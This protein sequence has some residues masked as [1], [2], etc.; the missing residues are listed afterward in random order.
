MKTAALSCAAMA[1]VAG[2]AQAEI[3]WASYSFVITLTPG[4]SLLSA[5]QST[6]TIRFEGMHQVEL[7]NIGD[8]SRA[9]DGVQ[10][11]PLYKDRGVRGDNP[12]ARDNDRA[13]PSN[14][15]ATFEP[16]QFASY[17]ATFDSSAFLHA[18][19]VIHRD[20]AARNILLATDQ[21]MF[22]AAPGASI[23]MGADGID[24]LR[25]TQI[26][27]PI[28]WMAP[29]SL[30]LYLNGDA[31]SD[32]YF[33]ANMALEWAVI[34]SPAGAALFGCAGLLGLRRRR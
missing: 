4:G 7:V 5:P 17:F 16:D 33:D 31:L 13:T 25:T 30:R 26:V 8:L 23:I 6:H 12:L 14:P 9:T 28:R 19:G 2:M 34:P 3:V 18:N 21:G 29:E 10:N 1:L 32:A 20:I 22:S 27:G 15:W 24:D 11:N